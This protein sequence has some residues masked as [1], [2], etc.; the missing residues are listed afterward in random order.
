MLDVVPSSILV[1]GLIG[2]LVVATG[3]VRIAVLELRL[4]RAQA[5]VPAVVTPEVLPGF[6]AAA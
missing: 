6:R 2:L 4:H 1:V 5:A 3:L